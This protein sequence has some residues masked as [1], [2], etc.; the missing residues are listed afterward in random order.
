[1]Q[2]IDLLERKIKEMF[3]LDIFDPLGDLRNITATEAEIR[4]ESKIVPF[5]PIAGNL[6]NELFRVVIH[7]VFG[8]LSRRGMLPEL[9]EKLADNP[10]YQVEF[11]S[12][13]AR[14]LRKLKV[15]AWMQTEASIA[16]IIPVHPDAADNF[17]YD[18]IVRDIAIVN[19]AEPDWL[20]PAKQVSQIRSDRATAQQQQMAAEQLLAGTGALGSNLGKAPE[21]GSPLGMIME[22]N[23]V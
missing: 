11:V 5:A 23:G 18:K 3:F 16:N 17:D 15:L 12:K 2:Q 9:P 20:R 7:R 4:N 6:H 21:P 1:M 8:I 22:G 13:I 10:E 14:A 19:G